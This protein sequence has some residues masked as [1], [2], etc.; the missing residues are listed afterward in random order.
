MLQDNASLESLCIYGSHK[1]KVEDYIAFVAALQHHPTLKSLRVHEYGGL[2]LTNKERK[3]IAKILLRN[4][5]LETLSRY[6][7]TLSGWG[8]GRLFAT[9]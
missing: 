9:E 3:H 7:S 8:C 2:Q 6:L 4:Y 1:T 5:A